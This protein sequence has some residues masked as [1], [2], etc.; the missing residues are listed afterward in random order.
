MFLPGP[1]ECVSVRPSGHCAA[2]GYLGDTPTPAGLVKGQRVELTDTLA[3]WTVV[4]D[5]WQPVTTADAFLR[6]LRVGADR[7]EGTTRSYAG[8]L[9][10]FLGWCDTTGRDLEA[11]I[12][13]LGSFVGW[14]RTTP[15]QRAGAGVGRARSPAR[16]N[17]VLAAVRELAKHVVASSTLDS[18]VLA[19][20]YEVSDDRHL[21]AELRPEG[22]GL[23]YL[24]RPRHRQRERR[25]GRPSAVRQDETEALLRAAR[26]WR[27]RFVIVLLWFCGLRIGEALGLRR[28]DLHLVGSAVSL[29]CGVPGP[30]LHVIGRDN[31]NGARAKSGERA[32]PVRAEV[33]S[34]YDRYLT[35]RGA[36]PA[37]DACDFVLVNLFHRPLG[38]PMHADTV[39]AWLADASRRAGL[40]RRV[41]P[42]MFRH[43]TATELLARGAGLDVVRELLG[44]ASIRSTEAYAHPA[45]DRLRAAVDHL[46][47][48]H[49]G[50]DPR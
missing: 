38:Q 45:P 14:L 7:A 5:G 37:A 50:P 27:D 26:S 39:R 3:Y 16:I 17:H 24:A 1:A 47:P 18:S 10:L 42:H 34:C 4:D 49:F 22:S 40:D 29:G 33:L 35:E 11:G 46:G 21:P 12:H 30:H 2:L 48:L 9:A 28:S 25:Q 41:R 13:A 31:P 23:R 20:L 8:D 19:V 15:V 44:H 43:A 6:H 36:C 32:M